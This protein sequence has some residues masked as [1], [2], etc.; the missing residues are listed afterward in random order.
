MK[1]IIEK[2]PERIYVINSLGNREYTDMWIF[3]TTPIVTIKTK[4]NGVVQELSFDAKYFPKDWHY[5]EELDEGQ[6]DNL[7]N[8]FK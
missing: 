8:P 1:I 6:T 2:L 5:G 4:R 7:L 3:E